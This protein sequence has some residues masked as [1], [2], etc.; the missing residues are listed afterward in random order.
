MRCYFSHVLVNCMHAIH[1]PQ[2]TLSFFSSEWSDWGSELYGRYISVREHSTERVGPIS[3][4]YS[5]SK[6]PAGAC[7]QSHWHHLRVTSR[8]W[9]GKNRD[10]CLQIQPP[11]FVLC[12]RWEL[13]S[14]L[15]AAVAALNMK[16]RWRVCEIWLIFSWP[17]R[18]A[19]PRRHQSIT[20]DFS[21]ALRDVRGTFSLQP[22]LCWFA[23][24]RFHACN[25]RPSAGLSR[26]PAAICETSPRSTNNAKTGYSVH[27][28]SRSI[29]LNHAARVLESSLF[30]Y[31][32]IQRSL[33]LLIITSDT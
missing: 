27:R 19:A 4:I 29:L 26:M 12:W 6:S 2:G 11:C 16:R 31:D 14:K 15:G 3:L 7:C 9:V 30:C 1:F 33:S 17:E 23:E 24:E 25:A 32:A 20:S 8:H 18:R 22:A 13:K 5:K 21:A 28:R 10:S